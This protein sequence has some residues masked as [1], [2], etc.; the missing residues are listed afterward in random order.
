MAISVGRRGRVYVKKESTYGTFP[1][2]S[3]TDAVRHTN[4]L[5]TFDP[6]ARVTSPEKKD[7]PGAVT[8]FA[9]KKQA[10]LQTL[11]FLL[12]PSGTLNTLSEADEVYEAAFGA[13]TN[14]TNS[15]TIQ[16]APS[17]AA[18]EFTIGTGHVAT[19]GYVVGDAVVVNIASLAAGQRDHVRFI[20]AI[21]TDQLS[22]EPDLPAM[23]AAGDTVKGCTTYKLTTALAISLAIAKFMPGGE[24][25]W[26][27]RGV[28]AD[29]FSLSFDESQEI[30]ASLS[31]PAMDALTTGQSGMPSDPSTFTTVGSHPPSGLLGDLYIDDTAYLFR[32]A[33]VTIANA[34]AVRNSEYGVNAA[35][36]AYRR[37]R[38]EVSL[39]LDAWAETAGTLYNLAELGTNVQLMIQTGKAEGNIAAVYCPVAEMKPPSIDDP[40]EEVTWSFSGMALESADG[41]NDEVSLALA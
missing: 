3:A 20:S 23:P 4:A 16:A 32:T 37:G 13:R 8:R 7:S 22:V 17:P 35:S 11:E 40:D 19:A 26:A 30:V 39:S 14:I 31:G 27:L 38:R 2:L 24:D 36:E 33:A 29:Q 25:A 15:S 21:S 18:G 34:M 28:P 5:R 9:R 12:R 6:F 1:S 10:A 41:Q